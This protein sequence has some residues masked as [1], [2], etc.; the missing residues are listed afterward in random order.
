MYFWVCISA[1][2]RRLID[3]ESLHTRFGDGRD[4]AS[5]RACAQQ[6][7]TDASE[8]RTSRSSS[9][10]ETLGDFLTRGLHV[11]ASWKRS[12]T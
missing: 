3:S 9:A 7:V 4:R 1:P 10:V 11:N 2:K 12:S 5:C 6:V 8:R